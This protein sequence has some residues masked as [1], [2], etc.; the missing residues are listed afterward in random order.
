MT[1]M[2]KMQI[3]LVHQQSMKSDI[4][5]LFYFEQGKTYTIISAE[6]YTY[7]HNWCWVPV[8]YF[9]LYNK[10]TLSRSNHRYI[11]PTHSDQ[12]L[13]SFS[14]IVVLKCQSLH[15]VDFRNSVL[16]VY[17][18]TNIYIYTVLYICI[19]KYKWNYRKATN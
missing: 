15:G 17:T 18:Y 7:T 3:F 2:I 6:L 16:P 14:L 10:G 5:K 1:F 11:Y 9:E 8:R 13:F 12:Q 19:N 4:F